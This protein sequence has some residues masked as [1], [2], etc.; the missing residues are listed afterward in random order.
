MNPKPYIDVGMHACKHAWMYACMYVCRERERALNPETL[1]PRQRERERAS[2]S[3]IAAQVIWSAPLPN[4][5]PG[6][7]SGASN[8]RLSHLKKPPK[9]LNFL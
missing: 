6:D 2:E 5:G 1:N 8:A 3:S 4:S 7:R 9:T